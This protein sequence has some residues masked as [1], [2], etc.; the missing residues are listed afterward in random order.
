MDDLAKKPES[1]DVVLPI[2]KEWQKRVIA[3]LAKAPRGEQARLAR[4]L[5]CSTGH[6][7]DLLREDNEVEVRYS[8]YV[9][10]INRFF[11]WPSMLPLSPDSAEIQH[12]MRGLSPKGIELVKYLQNQPDDVVE[13]V[14]VLIQARGK[15]P[16]SE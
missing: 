5:E 15:P 12:V 9:E 10:P 8:R 4:E 11:K 6:L 14:L 2:T 7:T 3:E 1:K 16:Q 13:A